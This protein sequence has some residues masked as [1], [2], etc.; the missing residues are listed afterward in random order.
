MVLYFFSRKNKC[1]KCGKRF[2][3]IEELMQHTQVVHGKDIFYH[4][5]K[6]NVSFQGM[7]QMRDHA[8]KSHSYNKIKQ[9]REE[10]G[11]ISR[12]KSEKL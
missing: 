8:R 9:E 2:R 10:R 11:N 5:K 3:K 4:C 1:D 7:E 6:C 12:H